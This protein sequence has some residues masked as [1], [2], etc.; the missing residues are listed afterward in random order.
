MYIHEICNLYVK[1]NGANQEC[2][3]EKIPMSGLCDGDEG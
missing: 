1:V 3:I 2:K